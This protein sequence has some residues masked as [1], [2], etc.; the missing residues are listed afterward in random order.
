[1]SKQENL[2]NWR[3]SDI[4][5]FCGNCPFYI[6]GAGCIV[7]PEKIDSNAHRHLKACNRKISY[8]ILG[9]LPYNALLA[10]KGQNNGH[11]ARD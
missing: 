8:T 10:L 7:D 6:L 11:L 2:D 9:D 3:I 4:F 1:M 5:K